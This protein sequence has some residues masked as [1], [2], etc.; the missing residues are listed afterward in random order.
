MGRES[1]KFISRDGDG[2][3]LLDK[4]VVNHLRFLLGQDR[5]QCHKPVH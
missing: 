3:H 1:A 4:G 5:R 2:L